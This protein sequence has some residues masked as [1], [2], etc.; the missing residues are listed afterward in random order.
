MNLYT[1]LRRRNYFYFKEL[2]SNIKGVIPL[3]NKIPN[4]CVPYVFP[5]LILKN[6]SLIKLELMKKGIPVTSWPDLPPEINN[7]NKKF[8]NSIWLRNHLLLF[9]IHQSI[10]LKE[11]DYI[12]LSLKKITEKID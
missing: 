11:I 4:E 10:N 6:Y 1:N 7:L 3:F 8:S 2:I 12:F 9:P 5:L